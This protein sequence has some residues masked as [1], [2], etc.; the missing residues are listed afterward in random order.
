MQYIIFM[1]VKSFI[2]HGV[3]WCPV[4]I[5]LSFMPGL[6]QFQFLGLPDTALKESQWRIKTALKK[7]GFEWPKGR[8]I[9]VNMRP[10]NI[11][12][13]SQGL[14]LAIACAFLWATE[15]VQKSPLLPE[16]PWVY[17]ELSLEG[18][19][20][21]PKD[22]YRAECELESEVLLTGQSDEDFPFSTAQIENLKSLE[23][24]YVNLSSG[25]EEKE[26]KKFLKF[27]FVNQQLNF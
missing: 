3:E 23:T 8:Q 11:R 17:G 19:V 27:T 2:K 6:P 20:I 7:Q 24:L 13:S 15:Q 25:L 5:E 4:E 10:S 16:I 22:I 18:D 9:I 26:E 12:K 14:E 1:R 21:A